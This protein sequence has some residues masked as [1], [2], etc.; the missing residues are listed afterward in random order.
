MRFDPARHGPLYQHMANPSAGDVFY[1]NTAAAGALDANDGRSPETAFLTIDYAIGQCTAAGDDY[2]FVVGHD[3]TTETYPI[4]VDVDNIHIIGHPLAAEPNVRIVPQSDVDAMTVS[5]AHV[6]IAGFHFYNNA[7]AY[8]NCFV[9]ASNRGLWFH[10]NYVSWIFWGYN[11]IEFSGGSQS[12]A[13]VE[14]N[15][16]GAHGCANFCIVDAPQTNRNVIRNNVFIMDGYDAG[17]RCLMI[18]SANRCVITDNFFSVAD[19]AA[20]EAIQVTAQTTGM[21]SGNVACSGKG[22]M[23]NI[24]WVDG[25]TAFNWGANYVTAAPTAIIMPA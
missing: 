20:G 6:E 1:V 12:N 11:G 4:V 19:L 24:P 7:D 21:A 18:S 10:H 3:Y 25:G 16:F 22:A 13:L 17:V 9:A 23:G 2:I 14:N 8:T 5:A 15:F